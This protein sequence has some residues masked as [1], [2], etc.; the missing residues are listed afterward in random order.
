MRKTIL[1]VFMTIMVQF[2]FAQVAPYTGGIDKGNSHIVSNSHI[3]GYYDEATGLLEMTCKKDLDHLNIL[4]YKNGKICEKESNSNVK[5]NDR[6]YCQ[7]S[8]YGS[9]VFTICTENKKVVQIAG[10][11]VCQE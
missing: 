2:T 5:E 6:I 4:I 1:S 11:V 3:N 7:L 10:T 8:D 9:G